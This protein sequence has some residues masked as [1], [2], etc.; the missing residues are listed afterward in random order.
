MKHTT[1]ISLI[2]VI[3]GISIISVVLVISMPSFIRFRNRQALQVT[4]Q[5]IVSLLDEA[6]AKTL[7]SLNGTYYSVQF[8]SDHA[9]LYRGDAFVP[10]NPENEVSLFDDRVSL[11]SASPALADAGS[12]IH[13][14]RL[15]GDTEQYGT[16]TVQLLSNPDEHQVI[17]VTALG[18][19][20]V[21]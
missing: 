8:E 18:A 4:T 10:S 16:I 1:G 19:V 9:V 15:T 12:V 11:A 13:F 21:Q 7:S 2:E 20:H 3:I 17:T 14:A 6:R 5:N